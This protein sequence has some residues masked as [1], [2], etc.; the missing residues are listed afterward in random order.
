MN[1]SDNPIFQALKN[2]NDRTFP[3]TN[4][5]DNEDLKNIKVVGQITPEKL[6]PIHY[7]YLRNNYEKESKEYDLDVLKKMYESVDDN[8]DINPEAIKQKEEGEVEE[9]EEV[10]THDSLDSIPQ[11]IQNAFQK[12]IKKEMD[13]TD[14]RQLHTTTTTNVL[15]STQTDRPKKRDQHRRN[16][17]QDDKM[18]YPLKLSKT[19][20]EGE[21]NIEVLRSILLTN[22]LF[23][24]K[25]TRRLT[26]EAREYSNRLKNYGFTGAQNGDVTCNCFDKN[27]NPITPNDF[28]TRI[29]NGRR[30]TNDYS[31][32]ENK[33]NDNN[34]KNRNVNEF[35]YRE[36]SNNDDYYYDYTDE[37][38]DES[39]S[40]TNNNDGKNRRRAN[41]LKYESTAGASE[42]GISNTRPS[43]FNEFDY[44]EGSNN[45]DDDYYD[46]D[47]SN[48]K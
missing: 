16:N 39:E 14:N 4:V 12:E 11:A 48:G 1:Q 42:R 34:N 30:N 41:R 33:N 35:E 37:T 20:V 2:E 26:T 40:K 28:E 6:S 5:I 10:D 29:S 19:E 38:N 8:E 18:I 21:E 43:R 9:E 44:N 47:E 22:P 32:N 7:N 24:L 3:S 27:G 45:N 13:Q 36:E 25:S 46:Y 31:N 23:R 15:K 17:H